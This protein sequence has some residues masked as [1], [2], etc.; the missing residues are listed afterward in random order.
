[1]LSVLQARARSAANYIGPEDAAM[2]HRKL[3]QV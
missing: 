2:A 3:M 1:M